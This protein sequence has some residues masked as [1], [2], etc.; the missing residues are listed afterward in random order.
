MSH[1]FFFER[2][3]VTKKPELRW[4]FLDNENNEKVF[5]L[6]KTFEIPITIAK[7]LF[8]RG[9]TSSEEAQKFFY[10]SKDDLHDPFLMKDMDIAVNRVFSALDKKEKIMIY[11]D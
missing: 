10:S 3:I 1:K 8:S 9:I 7:I 6:A 4:K 11:G 5:E 2:N